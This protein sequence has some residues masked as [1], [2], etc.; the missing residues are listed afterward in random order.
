MGVIWGCMSPSPSLVGQHK[1]HAHSILNIHLVRSQRKTLFLVSV[2]FIFWILRTCLI[3]FLSSLGLLGSPVSSFISK[4][5]SAQNPIVC[6][7]CVSK[8]KSCVFFSPLVLSF[9]KNCHRHFCKPLYLLFWN[10]MEVVNKCW[11]N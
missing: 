11:M 1:E 8:P 4:L 9:K 7:F 10:M 6:I 2:C 3:V 5:Q